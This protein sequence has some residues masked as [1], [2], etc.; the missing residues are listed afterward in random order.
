ATALYATGREFFVPIADRSSKT[1]DELLA[2]YRQGDLDQIGRRFGLALQ[3]YYS[4]AEGRAAMAQTLPAAEAVRYALA[5]V[6]PHLRTVYEWLRVRGGRAPVSRLRTKLGIDGPALSAVMHTLEDYALAF[7]TF[8]EGQRILFIPQETLANLRREEE[9]PQIAVGLQDCAAPSAIKPPDTT[10]LW[11]LAVL[12]AAAHHQEVELT[13]GGALPKRAAQRLLP[14][15]VGERAQRDEEEALAYVEILKQEAVE[16]GL[17]VCPPSTAKTRGRLAP[18]AKL[19]SWA[20]HDLVMQVRRIFRRWPSDR[21]GLD[22]PG[23]QYQEWLTFYLETP[24]A[25]ELVAKLLKSCKPSI[26]YSLASFRATLQG[27]NPYVLRPSQRNAGE[28]GFK[29]ADDLRQQWETTDG[30]IITGIFASTLYELGLVALGYEGD[31]VPG[32]EVTSNPTSFMVTDLG[33][34]VLHGDLSASQQPSSRAL[35]VQPN[36]QVLLMEPYMPALYWLV[37]YAALDQIGRVSRFTFTHEAFERGLAT[38][39]S[40]DDVVAFLERHCQKS[41]PQNF[42]F[43]LRD[44]ARQVRE[45]ESVLAQPAPHL[46]EVASEKVAG[47]LV[48]SPKLRAFRLRLAGPR[49][50]AVPPETSLRELW[51]AL[52]RLGYAKVLSG[53]EELI[54]AASSLQP[55]RRGG[56]IRA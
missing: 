24:L 15:L 20:R 41:L 45:A 18:G 11:D 44:W 38:G 56:R 7:D 51:R 32:A 3:A 5:R 53:L 36:F 31:M 55:R 49:S 10:F 35:V 37:R 48:T 52:E 4:R 27:D 19:E 16:L 9:R 2:P 13:R 23:A 17:V 39:G 30:E 33:A 26:W 40:T 6:E 43:T 8:R 12:V 28:A 22:M 42:L 54:A 29:L 25:R 46:F 50:V 14:V 34:E 1:L 47:E 21:W